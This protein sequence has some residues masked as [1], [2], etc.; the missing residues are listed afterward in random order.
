MKAHYPYFKELSNP[1][2][3]RSVVFALTYASVVCSFPF[4]LV[5]VVLPEVR[6]ICII[7]LCV[8]LFLLCNHALGRNKWYVL[9]CSDNKFIDSPIQYAD[10]LNLLQIITFARYCKRSV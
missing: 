7:F 3:D 9:I 6:Y 5:I 1:G 10:G 2:Y 4:L 8:T